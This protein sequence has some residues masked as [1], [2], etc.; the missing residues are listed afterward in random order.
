MSPSRGLSPDRPTWSESWESR[1]REDFDASSAERLAAT[2]QDIEGLDPF[3]DP[4]SWSSAL[5]VAW[6]KHRPALDLEISAQPSF[7]TLRAIPHD[8]LADVP[9]VMRLRLTNDTS[10]S[11]VALSGG[12]ALG[13]EGSEDPLQLVASWLLFSGVTLD[14]LDE[15]LMLGYF[16]EPDD[17]ELAIPADDLFSIQPL[18]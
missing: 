9:R 5:A 7:I 16:G 17:P 12:G 8:P 3:S 2:L 15:A 11:R 18:P 14:D 13:I 4:E 10:I 6:G 1:F